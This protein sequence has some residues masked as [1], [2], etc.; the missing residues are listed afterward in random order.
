VQVCQF[1]YW[2]LMMKRMSVF[3][4]N[5]KSFAVMCRTIP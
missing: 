3:F 5:N 4:I 1:L 2:L